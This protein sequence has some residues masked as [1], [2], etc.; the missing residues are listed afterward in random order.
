MMFSLRSCLMGNG[1]EGIGMFIFCIF[2]PHFSSLP[3]SLHFR[4][5]YDPWTLV[6]DDQGRLYGR[7]ST[8][9]KGKKIVVGIDERFTF[10]L[11]FPP[12]SSRHFLVVGR[13]SPS[14]A[15]HWAPR[16]IY[17]RCISLN[18]K[19][20]MYINILS[21]FAHVLRGNGRF[22]H[23]RKML[24]LCIIFSSCFGRQYYTICRIW[25]RGL[26]WFDHQGSQGIFQ[27][28]RLCLYQWQL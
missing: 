8:D 27:D 6:E 17:I 16:Y 2:T 23:T 4:W 19:L 13:W 5:T 18:K 15:W 14:K 22:V 10:L 20:T 11:T 3:L 1:E 26:G 21:Q 25:I 28:C 9:D 24:A 12:L 7:G